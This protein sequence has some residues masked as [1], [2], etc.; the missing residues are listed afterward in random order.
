MKRARY[1]RIT[2]DHRARV[3]GG[4][5]C[6]HQEDRVSQDQAVLDEALRQGL[7]AIR[8]APAQR[9]NPPVPEVTVLIYR[10][11]KDRRAGEYRLHMKK[12]LGFKHWDKRRQKPKR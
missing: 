10:I 6:G 2:D 12:V 1:D 4:N 8:T 9:E 11:T 5:H 3:A 7:S